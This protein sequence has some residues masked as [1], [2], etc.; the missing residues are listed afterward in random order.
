MKPDADHPRQAGGVQ[1]R[2]RLDRSHTLIAGECCRSGYG[3]LDS[4]PQGGCGPEAS[5]VAH[6]R[7]TGQQAIKAAAKV[8]SGRVSVTDST[9]APAIE[10]AANLDGLAIPVK[11]VLD[12]RAVAGAV[13]VVFGNT[14]FPPGINV[15]PGSFTTS[16]IDELCTA[17]SAIAT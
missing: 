4:A 8:A 15:V 6:T 2:L 1:A 16:Q 7:T 12:P 17:P 5:G 3:G 9:V 13:F 14:W 10:S 11:V